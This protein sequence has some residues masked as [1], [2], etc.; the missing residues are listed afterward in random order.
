MLDRGKLMRDLSVYSQKLFLDLSHEYQDAF[1]GFKSAA[2]D[3][4]FLAK[5]LAHPTHGLP[6]W[7]HSLCASSLVS[8]APFS[9][10]VVAVDGSQIY[11]DK[12]Q[13]T[14][15]FLVNI[16]SAVFTYSAL[17]G[18]S[19]FCSEPFLFADEFD[20]DM[21]LSI[22]SVNGRREELEFQTG[23]QLAK[24]LKKK[25]TNPTIL[26]FDGSLIFWHLESK[27][28]S[29]QKYFL[30][31][32]IDTLEQLYQE[33]IPVMGYISLPK[34]KDLVNLVRAH[35][36]GFTKNAD[37]TQ[38]FVHTVDA[39]VAHMF[40]SVGSCS[41]IFKSHASI[42]KQYPEHLAPWFCYYATKD[43]VVRIEF[44]QYSA[45]DLVMFQQGLQ[46]I[47]DQVAKGNGYPLCL[48]EAHMQ[49]VVKGSDREFF[50]QALGK[51]SNEQNRSLKMS[52]KNIK[53]RKMS[54]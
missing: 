29:L 4:L 15:C 27:E 22:D 17:T 45:L 26:L 34:S 33:Q 20:S 38:L 52:Q 46:V 3:P 44:P 30:K 23:L 9:Y 43:E 36:T 1:K 24:D 35:V 25:S 39:N 10:Q 51:Y 48:A 21:A 31:S 40:L 13:G 11:P 54:F 2:A 42:T 53:K 18:A 6:T 37:W 41:T 49:A 7:Q 14:H 5:V 8:H 47:I 32:Y 16:G 12:H 28:I 19:F 50:Y